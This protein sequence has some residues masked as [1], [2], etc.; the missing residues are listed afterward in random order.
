MSLLPAGA[1]ESVQVSKCSEPVTLEAASGDLISVCGE[2]STDVRFGERD[3]KCILLKHTFYVA[4]IVTGPIIGA[5]FLQKHDIEINF[6]YG[7]LRCINSYL[8]FHSS[9]ALTECCVVLEHDVSFSGDPG[10][11]IVQARIIGNIND[12]SSPHYALFQPKSEH[13]LDMGIIIAHALVDISDGVFPVR[14]L[15]VSPR[16]KLKRGKVLGYIDE[17]LDLVQLAAIDS[18]PVVGLQLQSRQATCRLPS[19]VSQVDL[20]SADLSS[21][22]KEALLALLTKYESILSRGEHDLGRTSVVRHEIITENSVPKRMYNYRQPRVLQQETQRQVDVLLKQ[23][24][25][26]P[27]Q[28]PWNSPVLMVPKKDGSYR[29]CVDFRAL[30]TVTQ[31]LEYPMPRVDDCVES[32]AGAPATFQR[33]MDSVLRGLHWSSILVYLDDIIVFSRTFEEHLVRLDEV[34]QR[35][36]NANLKLKPSKCCFAQPQVMF[37]GHVVSRNGVHTDPSKTARV[38]EWPVPAN[39]TEVRAFLGLAS[40][41]RRFVQDFSSIAAPL[42]DLTRKRQTFKWT[43]EHS[44]AFALLKEK[45]CSAPVLA[46]PVFSPSCVFHLKTDA[47]DVGLGAVLTQFHGD[48]ERVVAYG[49]R[50]LNNAERNYSVPE[51]EALAVVWGIS[52]FR[53]YLYGQK[54][55]IVT[56]HQPLTYLKTMKDPKGR[57]ARWLQELSAYDYDIVYKPG[58]AHR[59]ADALSRFPH[60]SEDRITP[61]A[62]P[63][64][65][66]SICGDDKYI[67]EAQE[68]DPTLSTVR[69]QLLSRQKPAFQGQWRKGAL[70]AY[71]RIWHQLAF[72]NDILVRCISPSSSKLVVP[73]SLQSSVLQ[74]C[75]DLPASG[76]LGVDKTFS[77][78]RESFYW[79]GYSRSVDQYVASCHLCQ[80]RNAPVPSPRAELQHVTASRP[81]EIVAMDILELPRTD[82]GNKYCLVVSDYFT[83]WPEMFPMCDQKATTVARHLVNGVISRHG[84]PEVIFSDQ[85]GSFE[86]EVIRE[87]CKMMGMKKVRTSPYHPQADGLVERLNRTLLQMLSKAAADRGLRLGSSP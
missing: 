40:Y 21:S 58:L 39:A 9:S 48:L 69:Q 84:I 2:V 31:K 35:L 44:S 1:F 49:S 54:F 38:R 33:L 56:D 59:D 85:G 10:E 53:P 63:V 82:R 26:E 18:G 13:L 47:C 65:A 22:Q 12:L 41:Y 7:Y 68:A 86:N 25:V 57:F 77:R 74:H 66:T 32:L 42:T 11:M 24:V 5:D 4:D 52:H 62:I 75:H 3:G 37:L 70:G 73:T 20:S 46:Y 78:V 30:N 87:F 50:K 29:F 14:L 36:K 55:C 28:S 34:F 51:R 80:Q 81:F 43:E 8:P 64:A 6:Q 16:R 79:P 23:G 72:N 17:S 45:L 76:H 60:C 19:P 15:S 27:S 71:R 61:L 83:R 67:R